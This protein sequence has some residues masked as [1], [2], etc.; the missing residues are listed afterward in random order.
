M[1]ARRTPGPASPP[2]AGN[3]S[4]APASTP[5]AKR[6]ATPRKRAASS[7]EE[8]NSTKRDEMRTYKALG[9]DRALK[10]RAGRAR[11]EKGGLWRVIGGSDSRGTSAPATPAGDDNAPPLPV[12][13]ERPPLQVLNSRYGEVRMQVLRE[14][15][16]RSRD[17]AAPLPPD[18]IARQMHDRI[19]AET[20]DRLAAEAQSAVVLEQT[21]IK[22][23][24]RKPMPQELARFAAAGH[25]P[26]WGQGPPPAA[27]S[28]SA[29]IDTVLAHVAEVQQ[30]NPARMQTAWAAAVGAEAAACSFLDKLDTAT[31]IAWFRCLN[32]ALS[33]KLQRMPG[34]PQKLSQALG[35][36]VRMVKAAY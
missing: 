3:E 30:N 24:G 8:S 21:Y 11:L 33:F 6:T 17:S 31:G 32:T 35:K 28:R 2:P 10:S 13:P 23:H 26:Q 27:R 15:L 29:L 34:L 7:L 5:V 4:A 14:C 25:T 19:E 22:T 1:P 20:Y 16:E 9:L 18:V 36:P 12:A